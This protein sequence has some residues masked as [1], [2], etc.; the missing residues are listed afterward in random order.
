KAPD[1]VVTTTATVGNTALVGKGVPVTAVE[2]TAFTGKTVA[3]FTDPAGA[4][5]LTDYSAIINWGDGTTTSTG[6]ISGPD[7]TGVFTVTGDHQYVEEGTY[8]VTVTLNR[9]NAADTTV[10][11]TATVGDPAV[12]GKGVPVTAVENTAFTGKVVATFTDPAGPEKL[13]D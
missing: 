10:T 2:N 4:G 6:K 1:T 11:T 12:V 3:T 7:S 8:S 9:T 13:S 5:P